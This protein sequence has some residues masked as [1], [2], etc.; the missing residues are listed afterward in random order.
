LP[1]CFNFGGKK[2]EKSA[3]NMKKVKNTGI[4]EPVQY[5]RQGIGHT[6]PVAVPSREH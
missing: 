6:S 1:F 3:K 2:G 4:L 5:P